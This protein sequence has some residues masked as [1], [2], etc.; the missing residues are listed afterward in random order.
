MSRWW[1]DRRVPGPGRLLP[2]L[3]GSETWRGQCRLYWM[4]NSN[5]G[6]ELRALRVVA[7]GWRA[8]VRRVYRRERLLG[9]AMTGE[10]WRRSLSVKSAGPGPTPSGADRHRDGLLVMPGQTRVTLPS[11]Q[12]PGGHIAQGRGR[13]LADGEAHRGASAVLGAD[14]SGVPAEAS[15]QGSLPAVGEQLALRALVGRAVDEAFGVRCI[16]DRL[17]GGRLAIVVPRLAPVVVAGLD[18][19]GNADGPRDLGD[20]RLAG[21]VACEK[22]S[23]VALGKIGM[24]LRAGIPLPTARVTDP[25]SRIMERHVQRWRFVD[26]LPPGTRWRTS[27]VS[28]RVAGIGR[29]RRLRLQRCAHSG[30]CVAAWL[31]IGELG[32][33][34]GASVPTFARTAGRGRAS[35]PAGNGATCRRSPRKRLEHRDSYISHRPRTRSVVQARSIWGWCVPVARVSVCTGGKALCFAVVSADRL[36]RD[37]A[38]GISSFGHREAGRRGWKDHQV[39]DS[40]QQARFSEQPVKMDVPWGSGTPKDSYS[41]WRVGF[42][43]PS[44]RAL[45]EHSPERELRLVPLTG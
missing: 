10:G 39:G 23:G 42:L 26:S 32:Y 1:M 28:T 29:E 25:I 15:E 36:P 38:G 19:H 11:L 21:V 35:Q 17:G 45:R 37:A 12:V 5:N 34:G 31:R 7:Q 18:R 20:N 24:R 40:C 6:V 27:V 4:V 44:P 33:V 16:S 14:D 41:A 22:F 8:A 13:Q 3:F 9:L 30:L 2:C 43:S